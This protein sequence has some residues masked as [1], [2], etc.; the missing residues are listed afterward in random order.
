MAKG[1]NFGGVHSFRDLG[2]IQQRVEE[3][4]AEPKLNL[5]DIPGANG[6]KDMS[7]QPAGRITYHDRTVIW[8][9]ALYPGDNWHAKKRQVSNALNGRRMRITLDENPGYYYYGRIAVKEYNRD[10]TLRQITIEA[11]CAPYMLKQTET[12]INRSLSTTDARIYL[13]NEA[14]PAFPKFTVTAE[15]VIGWNGGTFTLTPGSHVL[16][17]IELPSGTSSLTAKTKSG[18]G[19]ITITYQEGTL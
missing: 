14:K 16:L 5:I 3:S 8:T 10:R 4:P 19:T 11:T 12:T 6:S 18:T 9:F 13:T 15:T 1:T 17:D 7:E 2:L